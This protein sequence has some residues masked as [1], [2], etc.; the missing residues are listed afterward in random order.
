MFV[1]LTLIIDSLLLAVLGARAVSSAVNFLVNRH[2]VFERGRDK[3]AGATGIRYFSLVAV[4]LAA[5]FGHIRALEALSVAA[6]LAVSYAVQQRYLSYGK[7]CGEGGRGGGQR[8]W[9]LTLRRGA[10]AAATTPGPCA[11]S[12]DTAHRRCG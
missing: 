11:G 5:N 3:P 2:I 4:L 12:R 9:R 8:R 10:S 6:L 7:R 1:L